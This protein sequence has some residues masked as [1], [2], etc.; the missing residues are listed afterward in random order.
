MVWWAALPL[1][2]I[3]GILL[4]FAFPSVGWWPLAFISVAGGLWTLVGRNLG[5]AL[6]VGFSYGVGFYFTH[7][8]W[9]VQFL[10]AVPWVALAGLES[11]LFAFGAV[12]ITLAYRWGDSSRRSMTHWSLVPALVA[13]L[14][15][16]REIVMGSWPYGGFPWGRI[17]MSQVNSPFA[18]AASWVGVSG[19][20]FLLV[21]IC[22]V[23]VAW[24]RAGRT[25]LTQ[26][27]WG[28]CLTAAVISVPAFPTTEAG[29]VQ[30]GWVQGNGPAG[31][32]DDRSD[33]S[34]LEAQSEVTA[35]LFGEDMDLL[36][37]PEGSVDSDPLSNTATTDRLNDVVS[38]SG[39]PLLM[40]G[41]TT[42]GT[43]TFNTSLLWESEGADQVHDK[44]NPVPFGEY[45]PDRWFYE[46][47]V[48]DLIGLIQREYTPGTNPPLVSV[49][50]ISVGL[51]ICF[52]V[53]YDEVIW[54]GAKGGAKFYAFQTNNADFRG[55]D[56]NLQQLA[57]ARMRA[58]E[59]G[60]SVVNVS[61]VGTSQVI[62]PDGSVID[63]SPANVPAAAVTTVELRSGTT[64]AVWVG[65]ILT[66]L[67]P[68]MALGGLLGAGLV[69]WRRLRTANAAGTPSSSTPVHKLRGVA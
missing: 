36:I 31:Y 38:R 33:R 28:V 27:F 61:T 53:I 59:T 35:Q 68:L 44:A 9:V 47:I 16:A 22:A 18:E 7:L 25:G 66:L 39:V 11:V 56:E 54:D 20:T 63:G 48:P 17:G 55:T 41:A 67:F 19:L 14:W 30:V 37:W 64:P 43:E 62:A 6:L 34:V 58:I 57:F 23:A 65:P 29:S 13:V 10:G 5:G 1:A 50:G 24:I 49:D 46:L 32:F 40:N 69:R 42:R 45:V 26:G 8:V 21:Y 51:A 15:T 4:D 12:A 2:A 3:S 60:R 52:D